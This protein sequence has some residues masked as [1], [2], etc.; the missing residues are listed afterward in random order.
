M[1]QHPSY[2]PKELR[3]ALIERCGVSAPYASQLVNGRRTPGFGL[4]V[5]IEGKLKIPINW[6][7]ERKPS[8][9]EAA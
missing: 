9:D 7:H 5:K 3:A 1:E 4:A 6:W 8:K 2:S